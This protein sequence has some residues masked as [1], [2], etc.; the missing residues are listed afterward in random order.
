M[1]AET[2]C[3]TRFF[4]HPCGGNAGQSMGLPKRHLLRGCPGLFADIQRIDTKLPLYIQTT[5]CP[6][7]PAAPI[8]DVLPFAAVRFACFLL[9]AC[10]PGSCSLF[11]TARNSRLPEPIKAEGPCAEFSAQGP[12]KNIRFSF[13]VRIQNNALCYD[14]RYRR[15]SGPGRHSRRGIRRF[16]PRYPPHCIK[17]GGNSHAGDRR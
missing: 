7:R 6:T 12:S 8:W 16:P 1:A 5:A 2:A 17:C 11:G 3:S 9:Y 10:L 14:S 13:R 15:S 4:Q